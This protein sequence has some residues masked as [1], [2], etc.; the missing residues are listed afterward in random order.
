M[1]SRKNDSILR[2]SMFTFTIEAAVWWLLVLVRLPRNEPRFLIDRREERAVELHDEADR[3]PCAL[4][5]VE[6][7]LEPLPRG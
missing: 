5:A 7:V 2:V 4:L 3:P 1:R 6:L